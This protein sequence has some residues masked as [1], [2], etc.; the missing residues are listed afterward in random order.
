MKASIVHP[1]EAPCLFVPEAQACI[2]DR[3]PP[4]DSEE[5]GLAQALAEEVRVNRDLPPCSVSAMGGHALRVARLARFPG[6]FNSS[7]TPGWAA[8]PAS[9]SNPTS[10]PES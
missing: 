10:A 8:H 9:P 2:P 1:S 5:V 4:L 6:H 3:T 7:K